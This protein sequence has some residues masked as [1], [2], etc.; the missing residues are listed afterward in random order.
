MLG[1]SYQPFW[2]NVSHYTHINWDHPDEEPEYRV[3]LGSSWNV[4]EELYVGLEFQNKK[5]IK[6]GKN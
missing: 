1:G 6:I 3:N 2:S 4:G 5:A